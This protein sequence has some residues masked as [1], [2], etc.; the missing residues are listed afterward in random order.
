MENKLK[1]AYKGDGTEEMGQKI[2]TKLESLGGVN[3]YSM[4]GNSPNYYF[5]G[6]NGEIYNTP[7]LRDGYSLASLEEGIKEQLPIP[8]MVMT[9]NGERVLI[10][11]LG[12]KT[13]Y[14]YIFVFGS[15][16]QNYLDDKEYGWS[17]TNEITEIPQVEQ[18]ETETHT[19]IKV[20]K[21]VEFE[22]KQLKYK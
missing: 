19:I 7:Y 22:F 9:R 8:R 1:P 6:D 4:N 12:E 15:D 3:S 2:I 21:G 10:A 5:I 20:P 13:L 17:S 14:R 18:E 11:D 16:L